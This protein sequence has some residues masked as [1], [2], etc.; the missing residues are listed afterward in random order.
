MLGKLK[1]EIFMFCT[2]CGTEIKDNTLQFCTN[3]GHPLETSAAEETG[4]KKDQ[5]GKT[6]M[7]EASV[8]RDVSAENGPTRKSSKG[9]KLLI[10]LTVVLVI[11]LFAS[12]KWLENHYH[13]MKELIAMDEAIKE[14]KQ[15]TF[16]SYLSMDDSVAVDE[17]A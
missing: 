16:L 12:Y 7:V 4:L 10:T 2:N 9:K 14:N 17:K 15:D 3:C 6:S 8:S 5:K 1:G 11:A 13:P